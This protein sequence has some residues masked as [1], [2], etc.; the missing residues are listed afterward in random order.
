MQHTFPCVPPLAL[1]YHPLPMMIKR[2][3]LP[4]NLLKSKTTKVAGASVPDRTKQIHITYGDRSG[5]LVPAGS[6]RL[7][8]KLEPYFDSEPSWILNTYPCEKSEI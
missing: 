2:S 5:L 7:L 3:A 1:V 4:V 8:Q 6:N